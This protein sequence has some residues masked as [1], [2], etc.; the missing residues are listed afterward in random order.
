[1]TN[2]VH[3][4]ANYYCCWWQSAPDKNFSSNW[5]LNK[6]LGRLQTRLSLCTFLRRLIL[7]NSF[8]QLFD[9]NLIAK[10]QKQ[11]D[12]SKRFVSEKLISVRRPTQRGQVQLQVWPDWTIFGR[13]LATNFLKKVAKIFGDF[14][15][16]NIDVKY[17]KKLKK[18]LLRRQ[19]GS[20][21][22]ISGHT[23]SVLTSNHF[24]Q[25]PFVL[26]SCLIR[27]YKV[28]AGARYEGFSVKGVT[29]R[30]TEKR[31]LVKYHRACKLHFWVKNMKTTT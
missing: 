8:W 5:Y 23:A 9:L 17:Q 29:A 22:L 28:I 7:Q 10:L 24:C 2:L 18:T 12:K 19:F 16:Y 3:Y 25:H 1:M 11:S 14:L 21:V 27:Q 30:S 4:W 6:N 26:I 31:L 13:H 20:F 15:R